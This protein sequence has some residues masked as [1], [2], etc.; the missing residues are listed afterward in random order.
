IKRASHGSGWGRRR[1]AGHYYRTL[2]ET[3]PDAILIQHD[4]RFSFANR[5]AADL[6]GVTDAGQLIG[7]SMHDFIEAERRADMHWVNTPGATMW[8]KEATIR[9]FDGGV[10]HVDIH[11]AP[12]MHRERTAVMLTLRD[13][14]ALKQSAEELA[15]LAHYDALTGLPNR[16][17]FHQRLDHALRIAAR[18]GRSLEILFLDLDRFKEI[19]DTLGHAVGDLVLKET[20]Q[21]LQAILRESDTV[22]RLGGDEFVVLVENVDE[23]HRGGTIAA[24]ILA[25]M[26]PPLTSG[27]HTLRIATSIGISHSPAD[28]VDA[29]T[30]LKKADMAM[31]RVKQSGRNGYCYYS[32]EIDTSAGYEKI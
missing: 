23:P 24:K 25:A 11:A 20:A 8:R 10:L 2:V 12:F 19:N 21:R 28:G 5:A 13:I 30:L 9:R 3:C 22:A 17:L 4:G 29:D 27:A 16:T 7:G 26:V 31:Y 6:L 15:Y 14:T 32:D 1:G 18:P